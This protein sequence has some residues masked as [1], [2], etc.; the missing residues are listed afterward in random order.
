MAKRFVSIWF[1]NLATDWCTIRQPALANTAFV[2]T[3]PSHGRILVTA[4]SPQAQ[5]QGVYNGMALADARALVPTLQAFDDKPQL[6]EKLLLRLAEY[7]IRFTPFAAADLPDGLLL[8]AT[9]CAHLWGGEEKYIDSISKRLSKRGY[10][11]RAAMAETIGAAWAIARYGKN[12]LIIPGGKVATALLPL[13][14]ESLRLD[15]E[16]VERLYKLGLR[17]VSDFI[18]MPRAVLRRRFGPSCIQ[19]I[20]QALGTSMEIIHPVIPVELFQE[21]LP[22]LEPISTATGIEIALQRLLDALCQRLRQEEKGLRRAVFK[23][24]RV[25]G[26]IEQIS[27]GTNRPTFNVQ[28][29]YRLFENKIASIEPDL[30]IEL[31]V[32]EAPVIE[33]HTVTQEKIWNSTCALYDTG[34]AEL[35]DRIEGKMGAQVIHRYIPDE[36]YWPERSFKAATSIVETA[37]T[38]WKTDR[39]RPLQLLPYPER[40]EVTAPIPDY[41]PMLFIYKGTLHKIIKADGPE[42]I[43]QEWWIQEGEHRDYY[44][45][46]D[47]EGLRYW[48]FR[49]GHYTPDKKYQWFIHGFFS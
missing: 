18:A 41:P 35:L 8:D 1:R 13:P 37:N 7:C 40:I 42:R 4:A 29:L 33:G 34:L 22:C 43:E 12:E 16:I 25:D 38:T 26:K 15:Q 20:N 36:H 17:Q 9:G 49:S 14:P 30:G 19:K 24:Y 48:L 27:I 39:P 32:I 5:L 10:A 11:V 28:H 31:F 45:V 6:A 21:R 2:L 44:C 46:E 47:E 23:C 3:T